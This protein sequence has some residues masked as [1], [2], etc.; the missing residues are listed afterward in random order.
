MTP[1]LSAHNYF[2][3]HLLN[4]FLRVSNHADSLSDKG[5]KR[6]RGLLEVVAPLF[7]DDVPISL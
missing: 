4:N 1:R 3:I 7:I 5:G 6:G 2:P